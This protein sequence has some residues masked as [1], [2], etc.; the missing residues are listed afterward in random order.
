MNKRFYILIG[1]SFLIGIPTAWFNLWDWIEPIMGWGSLMF[2]AMAMYEAMEAKKAIQHSSMPLKSFALTIG[3]REGYEAD[4]KIYHL[5]DIE[6]VIA[7]WM[8]GRIDQKLSIITGM[9][10]SS[11][12]LYPVRNNNED[13]SRII[14]EPTCE[15]TGTLSAKYDADRTDAEV[16]QTISDLARWVGEKMNQKRV[17][18]TYCDQQWVVDI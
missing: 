3:M 18:C 15:Y 13:G 12:L 16:I 11:T 10:Q 9:L 1:I 17:Y 2:A 8:K 6:Q 7:Q 5:S 14:T 4:A